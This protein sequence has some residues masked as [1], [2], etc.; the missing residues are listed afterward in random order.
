VDR[1][2]QPP[3]P[4]PPPPKALHTGALAQ[5]LSARPVKAMLP[6]ASEID[7]SWQPVELTAQQANPRAP[8]SAKLAPALPVRWGSDCV[9][10]CQGVRESFRFDADA[11][12]RDLQPFPAAAATWW[13]EP[14]LSLALLRP[15]A[16]P[17]ELADR[18]GRFTPCS[19]GYGKTTLPEAGPFF[20]LRQDCA[21]ETAA[22]RTGR[23]IT[24]D[25]R[26][27][28]AVWVR[29][30]LVAR[31]DFVA[32]GT[33]V[34]AKRT[35][36]IFAQLLDGLMLAV[37]HPALLTL[38]GVRAWETGRFLVREYQLSLGEPTPTGWRGQA[39][40]PG[41]APYRAVARFVLDKKDGAILLLAVEV[42]AEGGPVKLAPA[43]DLTSMT[44]YL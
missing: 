31:S 30:L 7:R 14:F 17:A 25:P 23:P 28:P 22:A 39:D 32:S 8:F 33:L 26:G 44:V 18:P 40:P 12:S 27:R 42:D 34:P 2:A 29:H 6:S 5:L 36:A 20:D 24:P 41:L 37:P 4:L 11:R 9:E 16:T 21:Q 10:Q 3:P 38:H 19:I 43:I 15:V 35:A 13:L 1:P